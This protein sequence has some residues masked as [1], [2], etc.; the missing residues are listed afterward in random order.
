MSARKAWLA[1]RRGV[2]EAEGVHAAKPVNMPAL[3][4]VFDIVEG[5]GNQEGFEESV[6]ELGA[7]KPLVLVE[8]CTGVGLNG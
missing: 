4:R 7:S 1:A 3:G 6:L 2:D 8:G 5:R